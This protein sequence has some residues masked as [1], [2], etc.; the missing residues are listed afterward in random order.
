MPDVLGGCE[1]AGSD[2]SCR[3]MPDILV[4]LKAL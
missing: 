4:G 2:L 3:S 1:G